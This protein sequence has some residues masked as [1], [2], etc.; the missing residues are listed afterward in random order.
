MLKPLTKDDKPYNYGVI[1]IETTVDG[2]YLLGGYFTKDGYTEHDTAKS[3]VLA[4]IKN[5]NTNTIY[6]HCGVNFDYSLLLIEFVQLGDVTLSMSGSSGVSLNFKLRGSKR[7]ISLLDSY[8]LLPSSLKKLSNQFVPELPKIS[9]DVMPWDLD[10][11]SLREYLQR[12]CETLYLIVERF[13]ELIDSN[14]GTIR[15]NTLSSL[16]LKVFRKHYL[17]QDIFTSNKRLYEYEKASY[18]GGMVNCLRKGTFEK[19]YIYDV[20]SMYPYCMS[21]FEYPSSYVGRW[22]REY[23]GCLGLYKIAFD[24]DTPVPFIFDIY[25]RKL[26]NKGYAIVDNLTYEYAASMGEVKLLEGYEFFRKAPLFRDF[27]NDLYTL[28][29][30]SD[31]PMKFIY[32]ILLNSLYGKFGQRR[33]SRNISTKDQGNSKV[34]ALDISASKG[35]KQYIEVF[36]NL[37][38]SLVPHSFPA[39]ASLITLHA[40]RHLHQLCDRNT[41]Y[42]DTDSI[43]SLE[44]REMPISDKLGDCKLEYTGKA[45][46]LGKKLYQLTTGTKVKGIPSHVLKDVDLSSI[47]SPRTFEYDS[48]PS[49]LKQVRYNKPFEIEKVRR[50]INP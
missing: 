17:N 13:W 24:I 3:L 39:I 38:Y 18:F 4:I 10:D 23:R 30:K 48:F 5:E 1:D 49:I 16:S 2:H 21:E 31:E 45:T 34:Y 36:D 19:V 25:E 43:H 12:D 28:R 33:E 32:K 15:A 50:T 14:F 20:N 41:I 46:Y 47:V 26:S 22:V 29:M 40:R 9:L 7:K 42:T 27:V 6:A 11:K 44:Q 37:K 35:Y 8:R